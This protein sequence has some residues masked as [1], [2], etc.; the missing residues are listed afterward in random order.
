MI[1]DKGTMG[2]VDS[3][4]GFGRAPEKTKLLEVL[5]DNQITKVYC[6]GLAY[7]YCVGQTAL[8][9]AKNGF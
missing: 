3:Y 1:V 2:R 5:N 7:D 4:S 9:S 6:V 8:D